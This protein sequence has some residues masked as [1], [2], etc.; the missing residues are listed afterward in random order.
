MRTRALLADRGPLREQRMFGG[1]VFLDRGNM[2]VGVM[3]AG[4]LV[5]ADPDVTQGLLAEAGVAPMRMGERT[6]RGWLSVTAD[7]VATD[8]LL[9]TWLDPCLAVTDA[10]PAKG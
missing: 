9:R 6:M 1:L 3:G 10:L 4:L 5:R 7:A 8:A 2:V